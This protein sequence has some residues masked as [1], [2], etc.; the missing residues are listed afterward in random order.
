MEWL[1]AIKPEIRVQLILF[2]FVGLVMLTPVNLVFGVMALFIW[3]KFKSELD[4]A[5][6]P[7]VNVDSGWYVGV[8]LFLII[9]LTALAGQLPPDDLLRHVIS[10]N[11]NYDYSIP[12]KDTA[13]LLPINLWI[14]FEWLASWL[15]KSIGAEYTV[16]IIQL[17]CV[18]G[19]MAVITVGLSRHLKDHPNRYLIVSGMLIYAVMFGYYD[20]L[21]L[22]RPET[23]FGILLFS[24]T[25]LRPSVWIGLCVLMSPMY[26]LA[27]IYSMGALLLN[28]PIKQRLLYGIITGFLMSAFWLVTDGG[29]WFE[30]LYLIFQW[31]DIRPVDISE[32]SK[33]SMGVI[34]PEYMLFGLV[35]V[36]LL[37]M[38]RPMLK[39]D[40]LIG[41]FGILAVLIFF[42]LARHGMI[43]Y[44]V[45]MLMMAKLIP[46]DFCLKD[47]SKVLL[48]GV[49]LWALGGMG[50]LDIE[51]SPEGFDLPEGAYLFGG[52]NSATT[53]SFMK[54]P[55]IYVAP[56]YDVA[57]DHPTVHK[58]TKQ[59]N[60]K[61]TLDC[62]LIKEM[63]F[64]HVIESNLKAVPECLSLKAMDYE[65][66]LWDVIN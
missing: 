49:Y 60:M 7:F 35:V 29:Q 65:Y 17:L 16:R 44:G 57:A 40:D 27:P 15:T 66:R 36:G 59:L 45:L 22:G 18:T 12:Y 14:G 11:F 26:W 39:N 34:S 24:A 62:N 42:N 8:L 56:S 37:N 46:N 53:L 50:V 13:L 19:G 6:S 51:N 47:K 5:V 21:L 41:F 2:T 23:F 3:M 58:L 31:N 10:Y 33:F 32:L 54:N 63:G 4:M 25:F 28:I 61:N 9:A 55:D 52:M 38:N 30:S 48:I 43:F 1:K 64:T 20:R